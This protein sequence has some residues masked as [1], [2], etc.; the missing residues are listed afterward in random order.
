MAKVL[1][2]RNVGEQ[3]SKYAGYSANMGI[4]KCQDF[5]FEI[6]DLPDRQL[7]DEELSAA[8]H[9]EHPSGRRI[10]ADYHEKVSIRTVRRRYN[11]NSQGHGPAPRQSWPYWLE[12]GQRVRRPYPEPYLT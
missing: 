10:S 8:L 9:E 6:N 12:N 2:E 5:L 1:Q 7:T 3:Y 11:T 4:T